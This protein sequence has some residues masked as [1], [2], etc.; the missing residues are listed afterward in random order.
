M[1]HQPA[2]DRAGGAQEGAEEGS[3]TLA[4]KEDGTKAPLVSA[5][6]RVEEA[7]ELAA[8]VAG[9]E[10]ERRQRRP[11]S[12]QAKAL[13]AANAGEVA[14]EQPDPPHPFMN[15]QQQHHPPPPRTDHAKNVERAEEGGGRCWEGTS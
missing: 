12:Q 6:D 11:P 7:G 9:R 8:V 3:G 2:E 14:C 4:L 1:D 15:V 13:V 5:Q 10:T